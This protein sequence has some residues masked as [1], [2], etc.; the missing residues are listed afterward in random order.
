[1]DVQHREIDEDD[2][3]EGSISPMPERGRI[4]RVR[5]G[6]EPSAPLISA[7]AT[8]VGSGT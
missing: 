8:T 2:P 5:Q 7:H 3:K 1:V 6:K 4:L